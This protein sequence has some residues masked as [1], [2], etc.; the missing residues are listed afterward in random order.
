MT[1]NRRGLAAPKAAP[2]AFVRKSQSTAPITWTVSERNGTVYGSVKLVGSDVT[3]PVPFFKDP[4]A[5]ATFLKLWQAYKGQPDR[6]ASQH[7][8]AFLQ[9]QPGLIAKAAEF[10]RPPTS[11]GLGRYGCQISIALYDEG[12]VDESALL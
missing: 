6:K 1:T 12:G 3:Q 2:V 4:A 8:V 10:D 5:N 7:V 9:K 11:I